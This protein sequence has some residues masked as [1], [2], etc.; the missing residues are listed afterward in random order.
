MK[1]GTI[2]ASSSLWKKL[3]SVCEGKVPMS[4]LNN[5]SIFF[6]KKSNFETFIGDYTIRFLKQIEKRKY[7][8]N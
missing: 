7:R 5:F 4:L 1:K 3:S 2:L 6:Q 8:K